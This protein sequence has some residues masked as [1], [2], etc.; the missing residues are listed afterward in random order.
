MS[1][2]VTDTHAIIWYLNNSP[3][4]S[5]AARNAITQALQNNDVVYLASISVVEII[6]LVE[7][8]RLPKVAQ[9]RLDAELAQANSRLTVMPLDLQVAQGLAQIPRDIVPDMPDRII[10]A[11]AHALK[12]PLVTRDEAIRKLTNVATVW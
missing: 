10:A 12:L 5:V 7:K 4:L 9:D 2:V 3:R 8:G 6:Y 11:T 1:A